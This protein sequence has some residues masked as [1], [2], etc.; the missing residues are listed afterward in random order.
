MSAVSKPSPKAIFWFLFAAGGTVC[1]FVLPAMIFITGIGPAIGL[2]DQSGLSY[3]SIY[4]F[5]SLWIP[6]LALFGIIFLA[7]WHAAHRLR[8]CAH[9]F[10]IRADSIVA[11]TLYGLATIGTLATIIALL[12]IG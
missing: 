12:R 7:L 1:A 4:G 5:F 8:V 10:G 9:D 6:K 11:L 3:P 2:F